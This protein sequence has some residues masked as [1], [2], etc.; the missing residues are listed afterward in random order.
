[1]DREVEMN[2]N[3]KIDPGILSAIAKA[4]ASNPSPKPNFLAF[5]LPPEGAPKA[6]ALGYLQGLL[7]RPNP[8]A[9]LPLPVVPPEQGMLEVFAKPSIRAT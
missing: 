7:S 2:S 9:V 6:G 8:L 5:F 4:F 1:M 3:D